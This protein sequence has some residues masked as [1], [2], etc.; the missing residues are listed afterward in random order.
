MLFFSNNII[1]GEIIKVVLQDGVKDCGICSLLSIIRYY[2]GEVSKEYLREITNTTKDGVSFYMLIEAAKKIGF[3]AIGVNGKID[4]LEVNNLPCIAHFI[5]NK[6]YKHFVVIYNIDFKNRNITIMDPAKGKRVL[7]ISEFNLSSSNNYIILKPIK[8][9]PVFK[10]KHI[11]YKTIINYLKKNKFISIFLFILLSSSF[12][13]SIVSSFSF[14]FLLEYSIKY[15]VINNISNI[16]ICLIVIVFFKNISILFCNILLSK[17]I[18]IFDQEITKSTFKQI[19]LLPYLYFKNRTTGEVISRFRDLSIIKNYISKL[20]SSFIIDFLSI[21]IFLYIMYQYQV[22]LFYIIFI[23]S[24]LFLL[25]YV[26][27]SKK[28]KKIIINLNKNQDVVNSYL[29]ESISNVDTIK[30]SHLEKRLIDLF[31][32]KYKNMINN[33]YRYNLYNNSMEFIKNNYFDLLTLIIYSFGSYLIVMNS[34]SLSNII[35]YQSFF[36]Y[37]ITSFLRVISIIGEYNEYLVSLNRVEDL[38]L[39]NE[40]MF[41]YNYYYLSYDLIGS[42]KFNNFSYKIGSRY[43]FHNCNLVINKGER[44]LISG[45]SGCGKSTLVKILMRYIE[46][47]FGMVSINEIDINHYHLE[48]IR[49]NISYVTSN[50]YLFNDSLRNNICLNK[51][52]DEEEFLKIVNI[53]CVNDLIN[54]NDLGYDRLIEENGFN[55]SN[56]EKQRIILARSLVRNS[57]IYIFDEALGNIDIDRE[58]KI[59]NNIFNYLEGKIVIVISHRF[60]NKKLF[61]RVIKIKDGNIIEV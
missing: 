10:N 55:F 41:T 56:G 14:K 57:N 50:E 58:K 4:E 15:K 47:P 60:N 37:Y 32:I 27:Y 5:V 51:E 2:G 11:I 53:C 44:I 18:F 19:I 54:N 9:L 23:F 26:E 3:D 42:I 49:N 25:F 28:K 16:F 39:L 24:L 22:K 34:I 20:I 45:E 17:F 43:L 29:V 21:I 6:N 1:G 36:T 59:L 61:D 31:I 35:I 13:F 12:I 52:I 46:I 7:S 33:L 30:G 38:F 48:N 40:E 8:K